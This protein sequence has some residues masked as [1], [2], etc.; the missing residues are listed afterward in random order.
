MT[1][2]AVLVWGPEPGEPIYYLTIVENGVYRGKGCFFSSRKFAESL[3]R[4]VFRHTTVVMYMDLQLLGTFDVNN[5]NDNPDNPH[6][7]FMITTP[8]SASSKLIPSTI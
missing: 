1:S 2:P 3:L 8:M 5:D 6:L 4:K 7:N